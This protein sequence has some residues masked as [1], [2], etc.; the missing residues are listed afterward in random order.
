[1]RM[2]GEEP[3]NVGYRDGLELDSAAHE[4]DKFVECVTIVS[5]SVRRKMESG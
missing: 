4:Q 5:E 1:L 3:T 2:R